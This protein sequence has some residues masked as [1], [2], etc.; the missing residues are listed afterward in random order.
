MARVCGC[1]VL[2]QTKL[3]TDV[4]ETPKT[5]G[6]HGNRE[7]ETKVFRSVIVCS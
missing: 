3:E 2:S 1:V 5:T 4:R 7:E 6:N